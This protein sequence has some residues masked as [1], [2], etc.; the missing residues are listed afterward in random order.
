MVD[1]EVHNFEAIQKYIGDHSVACEWK[2]RNAC[3]A[4]F[5]EKFAKAL[6]DDLAELQATA[7]HLASRARI[8]D[9]PKV[10]KEELRLKTA[11]LAMV[12]TTVAQLWPYKLISHIL[13]RCI[14]SSYLNLQTNTPVD[15]IS[16]SK[17]SAGLVVQTPR[18]SI[19]ARHIILA[20]NGYTSHLV[21][22]FSD[23]IVP[24]RGSMSA[25][26]PPPGSKQLP[27]TYGFMGS[28]GAGELQ[29]DYL[30]QRYD[31]DRHLMFGGGKAAATT[32]YVGTVDDSILDL[33]SARYL[34]TAL[35]K[36]LTWDGVAEPE[37]G[38]EEE[39][40]AAF[41]W[42]GIW[43]T[44]R[45]GL[46]WVGEVPGRSNVWLAGGYSGHGMPNG[47]L[48]GKT[49]V[50]MLLGRETGAPQDYVEERL[51]TKG[52]IPRCYL[53]SEERI[54]RCRRLPTVEEQVRMDAMGLGTLRA[55]QR[56]EAA[57]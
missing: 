18:G 9:D 54:E 42:T 55:W 27:N 57:V 41:E 33:G 49:A 56:G 20:T 50:E 51:V 28:N 32:H 48:C 17:D 19:K 40:E 25:L 21:P 43:G 10:L 45:D 2:V 37:E 34:R 8:V 13:T 26:I 22:E 15:S 14:Q 52:E 5:T 1:F 47:K 7:P 12:V 44:S 35:L 38:Q 46:P 24:E 16:K 3:R 29:F 36:I 11:P 53:I 23:L 30:I 6:K 31:G 39:L 4:V